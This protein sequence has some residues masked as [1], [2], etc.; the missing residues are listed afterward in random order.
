[1][2]FIRRCYSRESKKAEA[3]V[4][5]NTVAKKESNEY[6]N[7][8]VFIFLLLLCF[9]NSGRSLATTSANQQISDLRVIVD[10]SGSMRKT[11]PNNLR[12]PAIRL[13]A[14]LIP[15]DSRAGIWYF[16]KQV[17]MAVKIGKVNQAWRDLAKRQS[18]NINSAGLFTN[19][20]SAMRKASYDWKKPDPR[21]QRNLILLT[22]GH[23]D[24]S[25]NQ[26]LDKQS[27]ARILKEIL[28]ALEKAQV[29]IHTIALSDEVDEQLLST[30][31]SYTDGLYKKVSSA[32]DLQKMF[33]QMLE[34]S[35]KLDTIPLD[36]NTF[37]VD[38]SINDMT[39]LVFN[40]D[41]N[42]ATKIITSENVTFDIN[43]KVENI[44]WHNDQGFDLITIKKPKQ[45]QWKIVAPLDKNNRVVIATNLKLSINKLPGFAMLGD[46]ITVKAQLNQDGKPL[47]DKRLLSKFQFNIKRSVVGSTE[48]I[49]PMTK[50]VMDGNVFEYVLPPIFKAFD[51][52]L[53][54]Q[55]VSPTAKREVRHNFKV[56]STPADIKIQ[57]IKDKFKIIVTPYANLLKP[58]SI[59]INIELHDKTKHNLSRLDDVWVLNLDDKYNE[60]M[61]ILK[62][63]AIRADSKPLSVSFN[64]KLEVVGE[65]QK[66]KMEEKKQIVEKVIIKP[67]E[68]RKVKVVEKKT[69]VKDISE[70][71]NTIEAE[72]TQIDETEE[73]VNWASI[74]IFIVL[75]NVILFAAIAAGYI[76]IKRGK[77]VK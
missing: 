59:N 65:I 17:N 51:N 34:Q 14:G 75:G 31:S 36:N 41:K 54:I 53:I 69:E 10:I 44:N 46:L 57:R 25:K 63:D 2:F 43:N 18:T 33:L 11:D 16:G 45:G 48:K 76:F 74:L 19:I 23:V 60:S 24:V 1:M 52:E 62:M 6:L 58:E 55:A 39:L 21:Y 42:K 61:F 9:I 32:N 38:P 4:V 77:K 70:K 56:Y 30:L 37:T 72:N 12:R 68:E 7:R 27:R 73:A 22:D 50:S 35:I 8:L 64:K 71:E 3:L 15:T 13:L 49:L 28:P 29:R 5:V 20:E 66:L 47:E 40:N 26:N 67:V